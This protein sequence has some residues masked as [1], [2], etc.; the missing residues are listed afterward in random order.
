MIVGGEGGGSEG[1]EW[2]VKMNVMVLHGCSIAHR[3]MGTREWDID[4]DG[5]G[6]G[7]A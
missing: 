6:D 3:C 5:G 2:G 4:G 1:F 7:G